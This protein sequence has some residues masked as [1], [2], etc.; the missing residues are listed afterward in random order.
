MSPTKGLYLY[1]RAQYR[2]KRTKFHVVSGIGTHGLS[3][4]AIK[5]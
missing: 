3:V 2:K 4:Q 5:A 1:R